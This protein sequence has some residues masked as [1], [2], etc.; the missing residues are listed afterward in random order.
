MFGIRVGIIVLI[1]VL[2]YGM[3]HFLFKKIILVYFWIDCVNGDIVSTTIA[4]GKKHGLTKTMAN[5]NP[6]TI[7]G[8]SITV[9]DGQI[10][11]RLLESRDFGG[12]HG[13]LTL[14]TS[15]LCL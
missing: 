15:L 10:T 11:V 3:E 7:Y 12:F 14:F 6:T 5:I 8:Q 2:F 1:Y 9:G 4:A 13:I